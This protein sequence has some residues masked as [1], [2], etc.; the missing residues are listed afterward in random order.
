[1]RLGRL[2]EAE[3]LLLAC[4]AVFEAEDDLASL[5]KVLG[6]LADLEDK[7]GHPDDAIGFAQAALRYAYATGDPDMVAAS[8]HNFA[9]AL[10]R[11]GKDPAAALAHRLAGALIS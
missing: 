11:T 9:T 10:E 3:R 6:A 2:D 7:R 4:R 8:H 5:G 1:L